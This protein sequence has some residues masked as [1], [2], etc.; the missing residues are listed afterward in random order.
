MR[1]GEQLITFA[2]L[3]SN[4]KNKEIDENP[5]SCTMVIMPLASAAEAPDMPAN[6]RLRTAT[7]AIT[8]IRARRGVARSFLHFLHT[9]G[10]PLALKPPLFLLSFLWATRLSALPAF[11]HEGLGPQ[12]RLAG[13]SVSQCASRARSGVEIEEGSGG[14]LEVAALG[15]AADC[16]FDPRVSE[17]PSYHQFG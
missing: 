17:L 4:W 8:I 13:V 9:C 3:W 10:K 16:E 2:G 1:T 6:P 5:Q 7:A 15:F 11:P 12:S 14:V